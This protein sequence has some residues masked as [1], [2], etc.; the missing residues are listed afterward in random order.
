MAQKTVAQKTRGPIDAKPFISKMQASR[1]FII[2]VYF[3]TPYDFHSK[4]K[5]LFSIRELF[6]SSSKKIYFFSPN[7]PLSLKSD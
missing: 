6:W 1:R 5:K 7:I 3:S 4:K 2:I